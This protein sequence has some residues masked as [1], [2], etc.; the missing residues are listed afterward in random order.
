MCLPRKLTFFRRTLKR[1]TWH[2]LPRML[3]W[4]RMGGASN[5]RTTCTECPHWRAKFQG[6]NPSSD[7]ALGV[8]LECAH[9]RFDGIGMRHGLG[10]AGRPNSLPGLAAAR[11]LAEMKAAFGG[12]V[13]TIVWVGVRY[14]PG[15][16]SDLR[17]QVAVPRWQRR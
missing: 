1:S 15:T 9:L 4:G 13:S 2:C 6:C 14:F 10:E 17:I 12:A 5:W 3:L 16:K 11:I 8:L 7:L